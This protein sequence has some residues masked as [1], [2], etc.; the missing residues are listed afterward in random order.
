MIWT[1]ER[2]AIAR[3]E[4]QR[5]VGTPHRDRIAKLGIGIDC[6]NYV[7]EILIAAG[8]VDRQPLGYYNTRVGLHDASDRLKRALTQC[9]RVEELAPVG[10]EFGDIVVFQTGEFSGHCGIIIDGDIWH[11]LAN[12]TVT[13]SQFNEWASKVACLLRITAEGLTG[14]PSEASKLI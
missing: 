9:L 3:I 12:R 11:A 7:Y 1:P 14:V 5:W 4:A 2:Q 6:I 8:I 13:R 10:R